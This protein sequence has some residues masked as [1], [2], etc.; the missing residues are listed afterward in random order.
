MQPVLDLYPSNC[1]KNSFSFAQKVQQLE[2]NPNNSFFSSYKISSLFKNVPLAEIIQ[3]CADTL[4]NSQLLPPR[5]RKEIFI[6]LMNVMTKSV[7]FSFDNVM[8]KQTDGVAMGSLLSPA[9]ANIFAGYYENKLFASVTKLLLCTSYI[10]DTFAIFR[11][12][13]KAE[14]IFTAFNSLHSALKFTMEKEASQTLPFLD[15]KIKK[16]N[17][18]FLTSI[19]RKP[20]AQPEITKGGG[21][22]FFIVITECRNRKIFIQANCKLQDLAITCRSP[23]VVHAEDA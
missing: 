16:H 2:F 5:F 13:A 10:D 21:L 11:S 15:V 20:P 14:K 18:Q 12:G 4:H 8:Y 19:Y 6:K 17:G 22:N 9:L 7:E 1:T 23:V 3:I